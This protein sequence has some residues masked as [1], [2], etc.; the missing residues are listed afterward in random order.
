MKRD[1]TLALDGATYE[2]SVAILRDTVVLAERTLEN[3]GEKRERVKGD[4]MMPA[5]ADA[6]TDAGVEPGHV[7]RIV[8]G[9]GA[10]KF[11]L[12]GDGL[13]RLVRGA[14]RIGESP[15]IFRQRICLGG[16][17]EEFDGFATF[18]RRQQHPPSQ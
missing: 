4:L 5:V 8:C 16:T 18:I 1:I 17:T 9:A 6:M 3:S 15:L 14:Q 12:D 11:I 13:A 7:V 10:H 2:G